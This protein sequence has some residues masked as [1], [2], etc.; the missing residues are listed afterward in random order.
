[1]LCAIRIWGSTR[2]PFE[3]PC[4][5]ALINKP[6]CQGYFSDTQIRTFKQMTRALYPQSAYV[7]ANALPKMLPK[8]LGQVCRMNTNFCRDAIK[9]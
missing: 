3:R 8:C 1:M 7:L 4:E 6:G 5:V 2:L 9:P